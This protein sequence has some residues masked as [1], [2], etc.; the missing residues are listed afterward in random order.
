MKRKIAS[1]RLKRKCVCCGK[2]FVKGEVYY[3][4]RKVFVCEDEV[5][6]YEWLVCARCKYYEERG[7]ERR[8][9]FIESGRCHHPFKREVW[10]PIPGE[11]WRYE[12]H[13]RE[14]TICGKWI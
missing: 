9:H 2:T 13:H 6:A 14:C 3:I 12:P 7:K 5:F 11:E 1:R 4:D 10:T 8:K